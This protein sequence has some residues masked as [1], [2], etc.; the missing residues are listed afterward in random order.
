MLFGF[1][2]IRKQLQ[3]RGRALGYVIA[4]DQG[5]T[6]SRALL[7]DRQCGVRG[8]YQMPFEQHFPQPGWVEHDAF[9]ILR[10]QISV[11]DDLLAAYSLESGD[12]DSIGITN[13][14]ETTILWNRHTGLPIG[15]AIVWQCR[16]TAGL[17]EQVC[18]TPEVR[19]HISQVTGLV[20]DAYFSASKIAW[21]LDHTP[22]AREAACAGDL[23]FGTVDSW[24]VWNLTGGAVHATDVTNASRTMLFDIHRGCWDEELCNLFRIPLSLLPTVRP[25]SGD[26]GVTV[27][28]I[29][30]ARGHDGLS[31]PRIPA[32]IPITGV[33]GDQQAALFGQCCTQA[34][35]AKN[36]YGTGCFLLMHT[37][38][39][40]ITSHNSLVSTVAATEPDCTGLAYALEGSVF[41]AGALIQWL[42]DALG[43]IGSEAE[44]EQVARSVED[45]AGVYVVP[46]FTG[47]GAPYWDADAR[48]AIFGLTRG[49]TRAHIVRAALESL[50][51]QVSDLMDGMQDDAGMR[52]RTL[53]VDGG[54]SRNDFLMQFQSDILDARLVR[55]AVAETTAAGAAYLAG[56]RT[57]F[58]RDMDD[59]RSRRVVEVT[60]APHMASSERL[61]RLEGWRECVSR[62][63]SERRAVQK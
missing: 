54:A 22:G 24:L 29:P 15:R 14:R 41:M 62:T 6:S 19:S 39:E 16:R 9:D 25:S 8:V 5:T 28:D 57:G 12:I 56:L 55:P 23:L 51:Y 11:L 31:F 27:D 36:T 3:K 4:L 32:G 53:S 59:I 13:Q 7:F 47:L 26:F 20:P 58:W 37:G 17:V 44:S 33:A 21:L 34:G 49:A 38:S 45:T 63:R 61:R 43:L 46:A 2:L 50:A 40:C 18:A 1:E 60:F 48:G 35:E 30:A 10:S 42:R 52:V